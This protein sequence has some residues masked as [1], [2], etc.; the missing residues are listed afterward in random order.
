MGALAYWTVRFEGKK[1]LTGAASKHWGIVNVKVLWKLKPLNPIGVR[2]QGKKC[3]ALLVVFGFYI[4]ERNTNWR[5]LSLG[6][7]R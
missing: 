1:T 7:L 3:G 4:H 2:R 6:K 5:H